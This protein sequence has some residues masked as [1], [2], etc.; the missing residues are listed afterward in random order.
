[1]CEVQKRREQ[2]YEYIKVSVT[3]ERY[4]SQ[5]KRELPVDISNMCDSVFIL[6]M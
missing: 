1:L 5:Y 2:E 6:W 3:S 4:S